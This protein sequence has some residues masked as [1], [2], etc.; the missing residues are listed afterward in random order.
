MIAKIRLGL[1]ALSVLLLA[2]SLNAQTVVQDA[3]AVEKKAET[4]VVKTSAVDRLR[5]TGLWQRVMYLPQK[6]VD[7]KTM[8]EKAELKPVPWYQFKLLNADGSFLLLMQRNSYKLSG[9]AQGLWEVDIKE[10]KIRE[11]I[12]VHLLAPHIKGT[13]VD[14]DLKLEDDDNTM[15]VTFEIDGQKQKET[16]VRV[17][18]D[19]S[20]AK[21]PNITRTTPKERQF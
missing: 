11:K 20:I 19:E 14:L 7:P 6:S 8:E 5:L 12:L 18:L 15:I 9:T 3:K 16:W 1:A 21:D 13:S 10:G 17:R 2:Y 4:K